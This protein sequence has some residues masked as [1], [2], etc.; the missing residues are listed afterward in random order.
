M[1]TSSGKNHHMLTHHLPGLYFSLQRVQG[2]R[3][4]TNIREVTVEMRMEREVKSLAHQ[5][6]KEKGI[7]FNLTYLL[8][9]GQVATHKDLPPCGSNS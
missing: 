5:A 2:L 3:I 7:C 6:D 8:R 4:E 1:D 9:L